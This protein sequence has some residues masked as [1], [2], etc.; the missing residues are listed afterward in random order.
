MSELSY[1]GYSIPIN[2]LADISKIKNDLTVKP[3]IS[4][5]YD[6]GQ[7]DEFPVYRINSTKIY[8]PKAYALEKFGPPKKNSERLGDDIS[9]KFVGQLRPDQEIFVNE[10]T[11]EMKKN[12]SCIACATTGTG[13]CLAPGTKVL[14]FNGEI[15]QVEN[16]KVG[17]ELMGP[18]SMPR[19][20]LSLSEGSEEMYKVLI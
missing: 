7:S 6:Y 11:Q 10:L 20:V 8:L 19:K 2:T 16:I 15:K 5:S 4:P 9:C 1:K 18:D 14:M 13:K 12:D 3:I 17:E